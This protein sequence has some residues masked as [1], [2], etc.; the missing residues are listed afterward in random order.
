LTDD[1]LPVT[2]YGI[3]P[4]FYLYFNMRLT[5]TQVKYLHSLSQKKIRSS[6]Q[7]FILEGWR[8]LADA[9]ASNFKVEL[10]AATD[11]QTADPRFAALNEQARDKKIAIYSLTEAELK[12]LTDTVHAQGILALVEQRRCTFDDVNKK[13]LKRVV[14]CDGIGD[15]GNLGTILRTCDWFGVDAVLLGKGCVDLYNEKVVRSTVGSLL[16][17]PVLEDVSLIHELP[18]F[19]Q[20]GFSLLAT[21]LDGKTLD[22]KYSFPAK[23]LLIIG[24]EAHGVSDEIFSL[25]D[26]KIT[27]PSYGK[28]ES[29]NAGIACGVILASWRLQS[30]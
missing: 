10:I 1:N 2:T 20:N 22:R 4:A 21:A 19:K 26:E 23:S 17:L 12:Y 7:K 27:I 8:P 5:K 28:A 24:S 11:E 29:L 9:L 30:A 15:P 25:A 18:K 13:I 3:F 6:E 16:H 14:A